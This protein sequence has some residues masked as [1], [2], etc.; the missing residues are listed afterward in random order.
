MYAFEEKHKVNM[1][2]TVSSLD[3]K[4]RQRKE[5]SQRDNLFSRDAAWQQALEELWNAFQPYGELTGLLNAR[6]QQ[7]KTEEASNSLIEWMGQ[8]GGDQGG[9]SVG[10]DS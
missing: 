3:D 2:R 7:I 9:N 8:A 4:I 5:M 10:L 1:K 6:F